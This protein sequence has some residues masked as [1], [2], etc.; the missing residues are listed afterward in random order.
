MTS[1]TYGPLEV[2]E[3]NGTN[4]YDIES[5]QESKETKE[6]EPIV[7]A[8]FKVIDQLD[9]EHLKQL[10]LKKIQKYLC[11]VF[12]IMTV[13]GV[14]GFMLYY[15]KL[16]TQDEFQDY[17]KP[18]LYN[19]GEDGMKYMSA[20]VMGHHH[21][22]RKCSDYV[23]GCCEIYYGPKEKD[24]IEISPYRMVK[25][26]VSG[27]NCP[28]LKDLVEEFNINYIQ[29]YGEVGTDGYCQ[30]DTS[31]DSTMKNVSG[32]TMNLVQPKDDPYGYNCN[33]VGD[34]VHM[35]EN[36]WPQ[37]ETLM[38]ILFLSFIVGIVCCALRGK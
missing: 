25:Q 8:K 6:K 23:Y 31:Y 11:L 17:Q 4:E 2:N 32:G 24:F 34:L 9:Q 35:Y 18:E 16:Q 33:R 29:D 38:D 15:D 21:R 37:N 28:F 3:I 10:K 27:S 7:R 22:R 19:S 36:H 5:L 12:F 30:I 26:D 14:S 1:K 13:I 20:R